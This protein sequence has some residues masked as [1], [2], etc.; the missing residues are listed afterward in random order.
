MK[1]LA[2]KLYAAE[3]ELIRRQKAAA[4]QAEVV[5]RIYNRLLQSPWKQRFRSK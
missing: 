2:D 5:S 3:Q 1:T 4:K